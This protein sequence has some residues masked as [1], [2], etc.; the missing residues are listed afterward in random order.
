MR[1]GNLRLCRKSLQKMREDSTLSAMDPTAMDRRKTPRLRIGKDVVVNGSVTAEGLDISQDGMYVYVSHPFLVDSIIDLGFDLDEE[2][3][4]VSAKVLH[5]QPGIGFGVN[6]F[7][8]PSEIKKKIAGYV[9]RMAE[10]LSQG[11]AS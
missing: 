8:F 10:E 9:A 1:L 6:F 2:R 5:S 4:R 7:D 11:A 3:I